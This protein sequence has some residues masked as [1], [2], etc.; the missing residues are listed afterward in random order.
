MDGVHFIRQWNISIQR[1][2]SPSNLALPANR[3]MARCDATHG[4]NLKFGGPLLIVVLF[5]DV[6][7]ASEFLESLVELEATRRTNRKG[8][9]YDKRV[10]AVWKLHTVKLQCDGRTSAGSAIVSHHGGFCRVQTA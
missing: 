8:Q 7:F 9:Q 6:G 2:R 5:V 10:P 1:C 3:N 4:C